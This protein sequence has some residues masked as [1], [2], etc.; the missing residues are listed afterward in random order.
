[1]RCFSGTPAG[2]VWS[3]SAR[4]HV[5]TL[6][7]A[8]AA[9]HVGGAHARIFIACTFDL[10]GVVTGAHVAIPL[11][12]GDGNFSCAPGFMSEVLQLPSP[13]AISELPVLEQEAAP[14]SSYDVTRPVLFAHENVPPGVHVQ[15]QAAAGAVGLSKR[16]VDAKP[17]GQAFPALASVTSDQP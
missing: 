16:S 10:S 14:D 6:A 12:A 5:F 15:A 2:H 11:G 1:M 13:Y 9:S 4:R 7:A 3:P 17:A 8:H